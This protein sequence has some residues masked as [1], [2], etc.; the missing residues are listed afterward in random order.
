MLI[1]GCGNRD[2]GDDAAGLIAAERL[3]AL[4]LATRTCSGDCHE[5]MRTWNRASEV[6]VVDCVVTGKR[7]GTVHIWDAH[8][9]LPIIA[10]RGSTHGF[11][12]G[13][14]VELSR[15]LRQLPPKLCI[16]GIEGKNF[17]IGSSVS[18]EVEA[19]ISEVVEAIVGQLKASVEPLK[20]TS[21]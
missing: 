9:K 1:I 8:H 4:R 14:A 16:Y 7:P 6:V 3:R 13:E 5:L 11:G 15:V 17:E 20:V 21:G 18:A 19:G 12:L 10:V 2:R